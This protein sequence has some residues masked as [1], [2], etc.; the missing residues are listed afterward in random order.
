MHPHGR[1][2]VFSWVLH[3]QLS[4]LSFKAFAWQI[5]SDGFQS[6]NQWHLDTTEFRDI[7]LVFHQLSTHSTEVSSLAL[8]RER[9]SHAC[10]VQRYDE[11]AN[12]L[13]E[14]RK[15]Q[16]QQSEINNKAIDN[17]HSLK[18]LVLDKE[19][20]QHENNQFTNDRSTLLAGAWVDN[21]S[22]YI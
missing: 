5:A 6:P 4:D 9:T 20:A 2:T 8:R 7:Q 11:L 15:E 21:E 13:D 1:G 10:L 22:A 18:E 14:L 12:Q 16:T 17:F 19:E 3:E